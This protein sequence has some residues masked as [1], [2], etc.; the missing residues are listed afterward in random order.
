[1]ARRKRATVLAGLL[2][3]ATTTMALVSGTG[4]AAADTI[5]RQHTII[6]EGVEHTCT[7]SLTR[8]YPFGGDEQV[9]EG[10]T[11]VSGDSSCTNDN[12]VFIGATYTDPEDGNAVTT[13]V[14]TSFSNDIRRRYAPI[15]DD[16]TTIHRVNFRGFNGTCDGNCDFELTRSK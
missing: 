12:L 16:F 15:G 11:S 8:T 10:G 3:A 13:P 9:G 1:M 5:T 2:P 14:N 6:E 7:I 4:T